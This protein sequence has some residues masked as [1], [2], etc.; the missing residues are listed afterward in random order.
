MTISLFAVSMFVLVCSW[1]RGGIWEGRTELTLVLDP[2]SIS[3]QLGLFGFAP[4]I[5]VLQI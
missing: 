5:E 4:S 2:N 1:E 3:Q